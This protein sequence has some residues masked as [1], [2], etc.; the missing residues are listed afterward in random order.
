MAH[1]NET[2]RKALLDQ[3]TGMKFNRAKGKL[4]RMDPDGRLAYFRNVQQSGEWH[5]KFILAGLGTAVT[6]IEVNH[7]ANDQYR[8]QQKFE[9]TNIIVEPTLENQLLAVAPRACNT[10]CNFQEA[11]AYTWLMTKAIEE[12]RDD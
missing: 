6:L 5:T 10:A 7:A 12:K 3:L 9:F 1:L 2:Q 4:L 11:Q 8:N